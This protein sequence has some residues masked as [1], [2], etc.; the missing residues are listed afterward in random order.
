MGPAD[1]DAAHR[2]QE[3]YLNELFQLK[4]ACEYI[5]LYRNE[6]ACWLTRFAAL[7]AVASSGAIATWAVVKSYPLLWG[8]IIAAAQL[9]DALKEV[10]PFTARHKAASDLSIALES[11]LIEALYEWESVYAGRFTMKQITDRRRT[12]MRLRRDAEVRQFP[13][14]VPERQKLLVVAEAAAKLYFDR[15]FGSRKEQ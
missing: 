3:L 1:D 6:I 10:V 13:A 14:G 9:A 2:Q 15:L 12:L 7:R 5:R 11:L 8:G 4:V